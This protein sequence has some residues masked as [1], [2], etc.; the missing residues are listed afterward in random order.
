MHNRTC[1]IPE[2]DSA[3]LPVPNK[4]YCSPRC[5]KLAALAVLR[6][7]NRQS[8][9]RHCLYCG[10]PMPTNR[11]ANARYCSEPCRRKA[12]VENDRDKRHKLYAERPYRTVQCVRCQELIEGKPRQKYCKP[13]AIDAHKEAKYRCSV[14]YKHNLRMATLEE[15]DRV[16]IYER[17]NWT[18]SLCQ[19]SIDRQLQYPDPDSVSI[20]HILPIS[21]GGTHSR[22]NVAAA[23]L[24]CNIRKGNRITQPAPET[25]TP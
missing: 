4:Q 1:A 11:R 5:K 8:T 20:D 6:E 23:H 9:P 16:E 7:K 2:C 13:C 25:P 12:T 19:E 24:G 22:D 15:F 10:T 17:D 21:L 3:F 14:A 18:C